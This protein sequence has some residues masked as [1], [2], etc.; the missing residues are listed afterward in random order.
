M[1]G[2]NPRKVF[3]CGS[4]GVT[5]TA[6]HYIQRHDCTMSVDFTHSAG[7]RKVLLVVLGSEGVTYTA[8]QEHLP[9]YTQRHEGVRRIYVLRRT[10][11]GVCSW[12]RCRRCHVHRGAKTFYRTVHCVR[13]PFRELRCLP[14]RN[15][16][17][18]FF[19]LGAVSGW[20]A[21]LFASWDACRP[22]TLGDFFFFLGAASGWHLLGQRAGAAWASV[23][24]TYSDGTTTCYGLVARLRGLACKF[25]TAKVD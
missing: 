15:S 12:S 22:A 5:Y 16:W 3:V 24:T 13:D 7:P 6:P 4:E 8:R 14:A 21:T 20:H 2:I 9:H 18:F 25:V 1:P 11:Q 10:T 19:F 17:G 23:L